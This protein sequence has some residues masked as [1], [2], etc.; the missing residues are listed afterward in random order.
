MKKWIGVFVI[1]MCA[2]IAV[3]VVDAAWKILRGVM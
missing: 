1:F 3:M 2:I